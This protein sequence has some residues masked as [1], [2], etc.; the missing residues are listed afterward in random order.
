LNI[1]DQAVVIKQLESLPGSIESTQA[2]LS[3]RQADAD[4][5]FAWSNCR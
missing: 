4:L 5:S 1:H 3:I 2:G